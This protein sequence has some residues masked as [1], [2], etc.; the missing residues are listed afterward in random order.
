MSHERQCVVPWRT[1]GGQRYEL[2]DSVRVDAGHSTWEDAREDYAEIIT[3]SGG[4]PGASMRAI[5]YPRLGDP[6]ALELVEKPIKTQLQRANLSGAQL[7]QADRSGAFLA[8]T[9][10]RKALGLTQ[11]QIDAATGNEE[12]QLPDGLRR[13]DRWSAEQDVTAAS[14]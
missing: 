12:T 8:D 7:R 13:P 11:Q 6:S 9:D 5:T 10:L 2:P 3:A 1:Q 4:R 14:S